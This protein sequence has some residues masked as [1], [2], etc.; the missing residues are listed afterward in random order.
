MSER[1]TPPY[2]W[3]YAAFI[4]AFYSANAI[5]QGFISKYYEQA[6]QAGVRMMAL[7]AAAPAV[8]LFSQPAWGRIG[9]R[10]KLRNTGLS[11]ML[12]MSSLLLVLLCV[13]SGF[14][15]LFSLSC[16]LAVFFTAI[17]PMS[18]SIVLESL[19][20]DRLPFGPL[21]LLG[22]IVFAVANLS[23]AWM[24]EGRLQAI[25]FVIAGFLL[26][27]YPASRL[28]PRVPGHQHG[29]QRVPLRHVLQVPYMKPL[30]A[31]VIALQLALGY[32]YSYF[33]LYFTGLPGGTTSL[34][35]LAY[36]ISATSET[37]FL[38]Y[39][40]RLFRR[41]GAGRLMVVSA[42]LLTL[43]F[44][45]LGFSTSVTVA[46]LSQLLHG[47][48]FIVITFSMARY[49]SL[50]VPNELKASGQM[51]LSLAG[52]GMA[53]VFGILCGG[54]ISSLTGGLAGGFLAMAALCLVSLCLAGPYFLRKP[55]I[56]GLEK[57]G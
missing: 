52:Y 15:W 27:S 20:L 28:L 7:M 6:G 18:D 25:P 39:S 30:M 22:S 9:D 56:N 16:L 33:T 44:A 37:F 26:L 49:I 50:S 55:P 19:D 29:R 54:F 47:G 43:R 5:Y 38:L 8:A 11:V 53:R 1:K 35:G 23:V 12:L 48:C 24:I 3:K 34:A 2:P 10:L 46:L 4:A 57:V 32:F 31:L 13:S 45:L 42:L 41:F 14:V 36:F 51:V 17:Q 40:D 21:R